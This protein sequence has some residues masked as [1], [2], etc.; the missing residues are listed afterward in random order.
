MPETPSQ[1]FA[2]RLKR[3]RERR[4]WTQDLLASKLG[5]VGW[6]VDRAQIA[7]IENQDRN[8]SL[9]E[10]IMIS[11]ALSLPPA[12]L[13]LPVGDEDDV[14]LSPE[15]VIHPDLARKWVLGQGPWHEDM[16]TWRKFDRLNSAQNEERSAA[17]A[18]RA[19]KYIG[20]S[21]GVEEARKRHVETLEKLSQLMEMLKRSGLKAPA[22]HESTAQ[23]MA[24]LGIEYSGPTYSGSGREE[25]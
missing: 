22:L 13:Y 20:D 25:E 4:G 17:R 14:A 8:I 15:V 3:Y 18:I 19:A 24:E 12:F 7:K 23:T 2:R 10:A 1:S 6:K 21:T 5:A 11:W 9:D 16:S